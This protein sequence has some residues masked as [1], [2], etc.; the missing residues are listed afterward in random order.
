MVDD[1]YEI[2]DDGDVLLSVHAQPGAGRSTIVGRHGQALKIRVAAA[3]EAGRANTALA[4]LL[5][6]AL[7]VAANQVELVRGEKSRT[8]QFRIKGIEAADFGRL[9]EQAIEAES[10]RT[11]PGA[12]SAGGRRRRWG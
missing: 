2:T 8:K 1:L 7:G 10:N 3:P 4:K 9:L 6:E 11:S 5:S 12:S